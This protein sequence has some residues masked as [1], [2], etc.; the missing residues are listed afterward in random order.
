MEADLCLL[1]TMQNP[2]FVRKRH[3]APDLKKE[4]EKR[5]L[6]NMYQLYQWINRSNIRD[7]ILNEDFMNEI[8]A[9]LP[10]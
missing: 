10:S 6:V 3:Q 7:W 8:L 9:V 5:K 4:N 1:L 2:H